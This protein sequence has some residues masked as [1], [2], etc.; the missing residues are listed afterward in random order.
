MKNNAMEL[1][2]SKRAAILL[3]PDGAESYAP[4]GK[5]FT[6]KEL[7][8]AVEGYIEIAPEIIPGCLTVVNEEGMIK[9]LRP[10]LLAHSILG[11]KYFGN[12]L[13][14]PIEIFEEPEEAE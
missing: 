4:E 1:L 3:T 5:Y 7:Q 9:H 6:L 8:K 13:I 12:I 2:E 14:C 11:V 10:N